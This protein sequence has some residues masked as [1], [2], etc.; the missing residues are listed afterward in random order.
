MACAHSFGE[1]CSE[2]MTGVVRDFN[3]TRN[4]L[5]DVRAA[6]EDCKR[7]FLAT[8]E[9]WERKY[10]SLKTERD[11]LVR[12]GRE[13]DHDRENLQELLE[14]AKGR[15][16]ECRTQRDFLLNVIKNFA[17]PENWSD[18]PGRL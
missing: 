8:C 13:H 14:I 10:L 9:E 7:D 6:Y 15:W 3:R 18:Q 17:N 11:L 2:C 1:W 12:V 5:K 4:E 16:A